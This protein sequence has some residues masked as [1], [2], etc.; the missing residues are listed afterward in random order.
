MPMALSSKESKLQIFCSPVNRNVR[1]R[2]G[3]TILE[4]LIRSDVEI[5]HSCGGNGTCGTCRIFVESGIEKL[6][7][8][9]EVEVEIAADRGFEEN[10]RLSCQTISMDKLKIF[11]PSE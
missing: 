2:P 9:T 7:P 8:R 10:E 4:A 11:I 6:P 1:A 5:S 3:E